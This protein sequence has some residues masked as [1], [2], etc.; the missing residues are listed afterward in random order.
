MSV[1]PEDVPRSAPLRRGRHPARPPRAV[2]PC[3]VQP[4]DVAIM[5]DVW[6]YKFLTAPQLLELWW[7]AASAC[8]GRRRLRKLFDAG[9]LERF[10]PLARR[11]SYPWTYHLGAEGHGCS[12]TPA[13]IADASASTARG[14]RLRPRHS[15]RSNSTPGCSH[16]AGTRRP[17]CS[18]WHGETHIEPPPARPRPT[19]PR[20][21]LVRRGATRPRRARPVRPDAVAGSRRRRAS[22]RPPTFLD[23]VRPHAARRQEL[24]QVPPLRRL[25]ERLVEPE[26]MLADATSLHSSSS[27]ARTNAARETSSWPPTTNSPATD[28]TRPSRRTKPSTSDASAS[29]SRQ[30][31]RCTLESWKQ[32][33]SRH[34]RPGIPPAAAMRLVDLPSASP[35]AEVRG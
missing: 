15:T 10:R 35:A 1:E 17:R 12:S 21:R 11:G 34:T 14:L 31:A 13:S 28:G 9:Y 25:R 32:L 18:S 6:R 4:R 27:S 2:V 23:R 3:A 8:Q 29:C 33:P 20:R 30:N 22:D 19:A 7:P 5:R 24:R 26:C 16:T